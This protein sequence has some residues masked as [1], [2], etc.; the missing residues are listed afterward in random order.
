MTHARA[1]SYETSMTSTLMTIVGWLALA[2]PAASL[3]ARPMVAPRAS[4][5]VCSIAEGAAPSMFGDLIV[6]V[7]IFHALSE[8]G[9]SRPTAIQAASSMQIRR[10]GHTLL[11][12]ATGSGKTLAY[13]L[14]LLARL[15]ISR[16]N[17]LL[18]VVP[19]RE[20][21]LQT[22][23][24]VEEMWRHHGTRR[25]FVLADSA[26]PTDLAA[27]LRLAA[28]WRQPWILPAGSAPLPAALLKTSEK[29]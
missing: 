21:A 6:P 10:G 5:S 9:I 25:A 22:A 20:L 16:P 15:H 26:S 27:Q 23:A 13:L 17:Q 4:A 14:P 24:V 18:I 2:L 29:V 11:H 28:C 7:S 8:A 3:V 12:S 19:S 1:T